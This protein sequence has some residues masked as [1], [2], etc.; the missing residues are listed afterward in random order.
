MTDK[1]R[2]HLD[3]MFRDAPNTRKIYEL[4]EEL[5]ANLEEKYN[6]FV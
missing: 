1:L 2:L 5:C 3:E 4:K 6:D